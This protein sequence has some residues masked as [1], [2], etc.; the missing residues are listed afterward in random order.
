M[1]ST[2]T[3]TL[4]GQLVVAGGGVGRTQIIVD[5]GRLNV[6]YRVTDFYIWQD[7]ASNTS[8]DA[9]LSMNPVIAGTGMNAGDNAQIGWVWQGPNGATQSW[10]EYIL[11]PDHVIVRDLYIQI[12]GAP[13]DTYNFMIVTQEYAI[14]DDMAIINIIK[15]GSQS[16]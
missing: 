14:S 3:R 10:K 2:R 9:S 13:A 6:G 16:L 8:F 1:K 7:S 11:D 12:S 15:E 4:R 5:D